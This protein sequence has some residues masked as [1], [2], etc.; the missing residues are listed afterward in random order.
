MG[1][2]LPRRR[3]RR[4][5]RALLAG[6][7]VTT[8]IDAIVQGVGYRWRMR[9]ADNTLVCVPAGWYSDGVVDP[10]RV[11]PAEAIEI[12]CAPSATGYD[13]VAAANAE[14]AAAV[15]AAYG[16]VHGENAAAVAR[17]M[18]AH[19]RRP[20]ATMT[21]ADRAGFEEFYR[22]NVWPSDDARAV[23]DASVRVTLQLAR[24][25]ES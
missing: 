4:L 20:I 9:E 11:D 1:E 10:A 14:V 19:L 18:S 23:C 2:S 6:E 15:S 16:P 8:T 22:R 3:L 5:G 21:A 24:S 7:D 17:F 13:A 12:A 25:T